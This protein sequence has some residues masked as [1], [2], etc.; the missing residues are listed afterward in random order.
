MS[1]RVVL[2]FYSSSGIHHGVRT[3]FSSNKALVE[4]ASSNLLGAYW[5]P[6]EPSTERPPPA[7]PRGVSS[8]LAHW[9]YGMPHGLHA[10]IGYGLLHGEPNNKT[11]GELNVTSIIMVD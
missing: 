7:L 2:S 11:L 8:A 10:L 6:T 9:F 4:G 3:R 1:G 5:S